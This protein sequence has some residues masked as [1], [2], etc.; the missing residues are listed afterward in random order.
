MNDSKYPQLPNS[1]HPNSGTELMQEDSFQATVHPEPSTDCGVTKS[2][3]PK[4]VD[5]VPDL[6]SVSVSTNA[7]AELPVPP[8]EFGPYEIVSEIARGG[9]GVVYKARQKGLDRYVALKMVLSNQLNSPN[10]R[11]RFLQEARSAA[12]LDHPNVVAIHDAG[13]IDG[14][15][16]FTMAFVEGTN[17][18]QYVQDQ[19]GLKLSRAMDLFFAIVAA[20]G[21]AHENGI[22]HRDLKPANV[23]IDREGRARVTDFGLAK[24]T[25]DEQ[26]ITVAGQVFGTPAY[27]APEQARNSKD[28]GPPADVYALG[29]LLYFLLTGRAPFVAD[30]VAELLVKAVTEPPMPLQS[31]NPNVPAD[32]QAVALKCLSKPPGERYRD[33]NELKRALEP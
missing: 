31:L 32:V 33:A 5:D 2:Q 25:N 20:V 18:R 13:E 7:M 24:K 28:V 9:M 21:H 29:A 10:A 8:C 22:I 14:K 17:L 26:E 1:L 3:T 12:S 4:L 27:M 15:L 19:D 16:F 6:V 23:L 30:S 11:M